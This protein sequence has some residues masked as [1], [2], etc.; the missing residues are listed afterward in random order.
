MEKK[1]TREKRHKMQTEIEILH[2]GCSYELRMS[3]SK[4]NCEK[5]NEAIK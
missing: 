3:I 1:E 5:L 2:S 4:A